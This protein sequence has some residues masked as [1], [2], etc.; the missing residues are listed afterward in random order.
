[1][2]KDVPNLHIPSPMRDFRNGS[3]NE[4]LRMRVN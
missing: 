1:M 3:G 2:S 4:L